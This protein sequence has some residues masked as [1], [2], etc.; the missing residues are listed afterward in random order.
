[1]PQPSLGP[2]GHLPEAR[3][4]VWGLGD[5]A[6]VPSPHPRRTKLEARTPGRKPRAGAPARPNGPV[7]RLARA[8]L[9]M[10]YTLSTTNWLAPILLP[11][12][13]ASSSSRSVSAGRRPLPPPRALLAGHEPG[14]KRPA[15]PAAA[16]AEASGSQGRSREPLMETCVRTGPDRWSARSGSGASPRPQTRGG[17]RSLGEGRA[18]GALEA[19]PARHRG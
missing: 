19:G 1:M 7:G 9:T 6:T 16:G 15:R 13:A 5:S 12:A 14:T 3:R 2:A 18:P 8:A 4:P 11:A 10:S 17:R